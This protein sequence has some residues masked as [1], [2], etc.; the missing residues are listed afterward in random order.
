MTKE[1]YTIH[2]I[3]LF[4]GLTPRTLRNY[5]RLGLLAGEKADGAW[6]FTPEQVDAFLT[7]PAVWSSIQAKKNALVYDFMLSK[8]KSTRSLCAILD[9]PGEDSQALS[10]FFC[11]QINSGRFGPG[12]RFSLEN[13][14]RYPR[15]I[16]SGPAEAVET[17]LALFQRCVPAGEIPEP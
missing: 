6:R 9:L 7:N 13:S 10:E 14:G 11:G 16:V 15:V 8:T 2:D 17:L 5:L 1:S 12:F 3:C 4:S